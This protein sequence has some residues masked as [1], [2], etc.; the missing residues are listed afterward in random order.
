MQSSGAEEVEVEVEV[1][2]EGQGGARKVGPEG[3]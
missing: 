1:E 3:L 2:V